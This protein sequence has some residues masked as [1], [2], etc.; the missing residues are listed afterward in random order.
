MLIGESHPPIGHVADTQ[1]RFLVKGRLICFDSGKRSRLSGSAGT[2]GFL[3][4]GAPRPRETDIIGRYSGEEIVIVLPECDPIEA[5]K[6]V[7]EIG[8]HFASHVVTT[9]EIRL[10]VTLS[11]GV[12]ELGQFE[13]GDA[14][15]HPRKAGGRQG[16]SIYQMP[17]ISGPTERRASR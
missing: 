12:A 5:S 11:A 9:N 6:F 17:G 14:A 10:H 13:I 16:V 4:E 8:R 7:K 15:H 3:R 1:R 2:F